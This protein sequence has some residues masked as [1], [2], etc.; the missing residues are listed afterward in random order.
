AW[1]RSAN[2]NPFLPLQ[3]QRMRNVPHSSPQ[4]EL[5]FTRILTD[6]LV[7]SS[8]N[9]VVS[10]PHKESDSDLRPSPM[11][12]EIRE[13]CVDE[14]ELSDSSDHA[15]LLFQT[16][17]LENLIDSHAP[18]WT[19]TTLRGGSSMFTY[20]SAC[21]FRS[22]A[23][24]RLGAETLDSP[25]AGLN[26]AER[27]MLVHDVL[28]RV[29]DEFGSHQTLVDSSQEFINAVIVDEVRAAISSMATKKAAL[30]DPRYA[31]IEQFRLERLVGDWLELEKE[32]KPFIVLPLEQ[33]QEVQ[34]GGIGIFLKTDRID[35]L[36]DGSHIILDYKTSMHSP[37][38][39]E[40]LRPEEP[41]LPLY[42]VTAG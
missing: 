32:R 37:K 30:R 14:L 16:S 19:A 15:E 24:L 28:R 22:F 26:A 10:Y 18:P 33:Q 35:R 41:Q 42:A 23:K 27:G 25:S 40:G 8:P 4:R 13:M 36:Q 5:A 6:Q 31:A 2:A 3:L 1:P 29:W 34:F 39:W 11:I 21:A 7:A 38:E 20:Q 17:Q 9:V 12:S